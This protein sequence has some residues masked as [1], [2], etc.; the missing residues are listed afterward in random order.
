MH[1]CEDVLYVGHCRETV[2]GLT[3]PQSQENGI[4]LSCPLEDG[5]THIGILDAQL[6]NVNRGYA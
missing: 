1:V 5:N 4:R 3:E 6:R 2:L